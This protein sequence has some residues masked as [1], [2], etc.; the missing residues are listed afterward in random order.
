M[1]PNIAKGPFEDVE[2]VGQAGAGRGKISEILREP[3]IKGGRKLLYFQIPL[4]QL[5][6]HVVPM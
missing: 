6:L 2:G 1:S 5:L 4:A 3:L